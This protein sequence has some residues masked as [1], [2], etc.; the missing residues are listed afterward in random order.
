[1]AAGTPKTET[2]TIPRVIIVMTSS[3][4]A[5]FDSFST[6]EDIVDT[7]PVDNKDNFE[8]GLR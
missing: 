1:M 3:K 4:E 5:I 8:G 6:K 2:F 7:I